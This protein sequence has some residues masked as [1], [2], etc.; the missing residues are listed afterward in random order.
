[1]NQPKKINIYSDGSCLSNPGPGGYCA[2]LT[3][4][5]AE[6]IISGGDAET[7]NNRMELLAAISGL[8]A[9]KDNMNC[10][11]DLY[12]DSKYIVDGIEKGWAV[13]WR[14]NNWRKSDKK[15]ALNFELW[16]RLLNAIEKLDNR[17]KLIWL[18]GHAGHEYNERCDEIARNIALEY[19]NNL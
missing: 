13:N 1:M 6:K 16:E 11:V 17:V 14:K 10:D 3:Y 19:K 9:V 5:D 2:I 7:T 12:T 15:P 18:K 4:R 8:E